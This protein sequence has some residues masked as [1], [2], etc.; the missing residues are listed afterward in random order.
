MAN[1]VTFHLPGD[2]DSFLQ[3]VAQM[4]GGFSYS[5]MI[6]FYPTKEQKSQLR[7]L[8]EQM[9]DADESERPSLAAKVAVVVNPDVI[10]KGCGWHLDYGC[11]PEVS[12][13]AV[14][15]PNCNAIIDQT[16]KVL[17]K[18]VS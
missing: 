11:Q 3:D 15:C 8:Y 16:G 9:C 1:P 4:Y 6:K 2:L 7:E 12:M 18:E 13:E 10:C 17:S 5:D 14:K